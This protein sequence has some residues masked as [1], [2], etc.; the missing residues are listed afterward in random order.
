MDSNP[1]GRTLLLCQHYLQVPSP[2]SWIPNQHIQ[3]MLLHS[4]ALPEALSD[5]GKLYCMIY[6]S[7]VLNFTK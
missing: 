3:P 2:T 6:I 5:Q 7:I 4:V 1:L